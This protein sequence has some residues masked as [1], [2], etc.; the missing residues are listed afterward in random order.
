MIK[1]L[2]KVVSG[3][4]SPFLIPTYIYVIF[5][6]TSNLSILPLSGK[7]LITAII[8]IFTSLIPFVAIKWNFKDEEVEKKRLLHPYVIMGICYLFSIYML[9]AIG[10]PQWATSYMLSCVVAVVILA[11]IRKILNISIHAVATG[12][13]IGAVCSF[14]SILFAIPMELLCVTI[15]CAGAVDSCRLYL[16]GYTL[17]DVFGGNALGFVLSYFSTY[18][19]NL[20]LN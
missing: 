18:Y 17:K 2:C 14:K 4:L 11:L 10:F 3:I 12:V 9:S 5:I 1:S 13:L 8:A 6:L 19:V 15:I 16:K 20:I 7:L